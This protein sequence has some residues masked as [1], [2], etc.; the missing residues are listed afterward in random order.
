MG[1]RAVIRPRALSKG[2]RVALVAPAGPLTERDDLTRARELCDGLGWEPVPGPRALGRHGYL[3]GNDEDRLADLNQMLRD[4]AVDAVW[5]LRGG[6]GV[7]RILDQVDFGALAARPRPLIGFSDITALLLASLGETGVIPFHG[8]MARAPLTRFSREH[9]ERVVTR[10]AAAGTLG[11]LAPPEGVLAPRAHRIVPI[12]G[13]VA[14]GPLVGGNLSLLTALAGTR[15]FPVLDGAILFLEEV[16]EDL[17]R[18]DRMLA[19]LRMLGALERVA[20]VIV[21]QFTDMKRGTGDGALGF[22]EV[23]TTYIGPLG[24]PAAY[25]FPIGHVDDQW[26]LPLGVRARLDAGAGEVVVLEPAVA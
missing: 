12:R 6:F 14:D 7:T 13:G 9:L 26:T 4:P 2:S 18:V 23:L 20:G 17:Y 21:G 8:P 5:C 11:R 22:D 25:G 16:G 24:V 19:H 1:S 10:P 15:F 3:A